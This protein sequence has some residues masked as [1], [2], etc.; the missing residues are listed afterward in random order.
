MA[1]CEAAKPMPLVAVERNLNTS[2]PQARHSVS[3]QQPSQ[4]QPVQEQQQMTQYHQNREWIDQVAQMSEQ[5]PGAA[6]S[7]GTMQ[8]HGVSSY[9][10]NEKKQLQRQMQQLQQPVQEQQQMT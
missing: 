9:Q 10:M 2:N 3:E 8:H 5:R 7:M 1:A 6:S 4:Q